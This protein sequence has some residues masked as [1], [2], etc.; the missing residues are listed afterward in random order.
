MYCIVCG[1]TWPSW[2]WNEG[3]IM[4]WIMWK[5]WSNTLE[6]LVSLKVYFSGGVS[7]QGHCQENMKQIAEHA[8]FICL[9][10]LVWSGWSSKSGFVSF[11]STH[12]HVCTDTL[13]HT[14]LTALLWG[15]CRWMH[16][17]Q[18]ET[19]RASRGERE[20]WM[21]RQKTKKDKDGESV[22]LDSKSWD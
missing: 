11:I 10:G 5:A 16:R 18:R 15:V 1:Y 20:R 8:Y 13:K 21:K 19:G 2:P 7:A 4:H 12:T 14:W 17:R 9:S 6:A 22:R 3:L